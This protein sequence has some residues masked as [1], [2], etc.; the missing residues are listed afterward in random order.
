VAMDL[1]RTVGFVNQQ[2]GLTVSSAWLFGAGAELEV[3]YLSSALKMPVRPSPVPASPFYWAEQ[4]AKLPVKDDGNLVT[5]ETREAPQRRR[6]LAIAAAVVVLVLVGSLA[7]AGYLEVLRRDELDTIAA[8]ESDVTKLQK[9]V[10]QLEKREA[11][12]KSKRELVEFVR[13]GTLPP[14]PGWFLGYVSEAVP[15]SLVLTQLKV[16]RTNDQWHV[17]LGGSLHPTTNAAPGTILHQAVTTLTNELAAGPFHLRIQ[18]SSV[19]DTPAGA[20]QFSIEGVA[21]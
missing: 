1:T 17:S 19:E 14:V 12:L 5:R 13:D 20:K 8:L 9:R 10:G 16:T 3:T 6:M 2:S 7:G 4:A 11:E 15:E 18:R 21:Q